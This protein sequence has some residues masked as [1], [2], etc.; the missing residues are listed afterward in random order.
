MN[1]RRITRQMAIQYINDL[2]PPDSE[3]DD[4]RTIGRDIMDSTVGNQV[5]YNNWRDL[6]E[7][8]LI[9]LAIANLEEAGED[10]S[11]YV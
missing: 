11:K 10:T 3:Y 9:K 4:S 8:S 6:P 1:K 5:G 7:E 2:Y